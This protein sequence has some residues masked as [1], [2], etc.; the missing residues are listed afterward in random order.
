MFRRDH[1]EGVSCRNR[2]VAVGLA[3]RVNGERTTAFIDRRY[4]PAMPLR[5]G[6]AAG[7]AVPAAYRKVVWTGIGYLSL[8]QARDLTRLAR[9]RSSRADFGYSK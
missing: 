4:A 7:T 8:K 9:K 6:N 3:M 5:G 2:V 1:N